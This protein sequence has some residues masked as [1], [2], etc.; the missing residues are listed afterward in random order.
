MKRKRPSNLENRPRDT[1]DDFDLSHYVLVQ[2][3]S[4]IADQP[5]RAAS[6]VA[7][8]DH[9]TQATAAQ[10]ALVNWKITSGSTH[11]DG[12]DDMWVDRYGIP[13]AS[14]LQRRI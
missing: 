6:V 9:E 11:D 10:K 3:A 12:V 5:L 14:W 1:A 2:E 4:L 8:H 13:F 7:H